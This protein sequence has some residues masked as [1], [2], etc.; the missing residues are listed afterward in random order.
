[1]GK[2]KAMWNT[3]RFKGI[4]AIVLVFA[5]IAAI[6][7]VELSG[8]RFHYAQKALELL[9]ADKVV[10]KAQSCATL[11]VDTLV[12]Y[13]PENDA[14]IQAYE[15]FEVIL[16]DMK[17]GFSA[18]DITAVQ[19]PAFEDYSLVIVLFSDLSYLGND[20]I[21]LCSWVHNGGNVLF[22]LTLDKNAHSSAIENKIGI[23]A[24]YG[25]SYVGNIYINEGFMLGGGRAFAISDAYESARTVQLNPRTTKV[26]ASV[27][28]SG[29][30]PLIW[31][32]NYGQGKFV[33]A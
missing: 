14:S 20:L 5:L 32:A 27:D 7:L 17:V 22:P 11:D 16:Q 13:S 19:L 18:V 30:V 6:L 8:V 1:M 10:T 3:F 31:E 26:H 12:L 24:S 15:Q 21:H 2:L 29:G 25:Y 23:E 28:Q 9:P 4:L 33:V